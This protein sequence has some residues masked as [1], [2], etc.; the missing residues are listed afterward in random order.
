M[1]DARQIINR[2]ADLKSQRTVHEDAWRECFEYSWPSRADGFN[3]VRQD[4]QQILDKKAQNV[5]ST[6][7]DAGRLLA[8]AIQSGAT[9]AN[10]RWF[11]LD[12]NGADDQATR[13]LDDAAQTLFELIH[14]ANFDAA[15]FE[16]CIDIVGAG[17]FA[18]YVD[19]ESAGGGFNFEQ[20]PISQLYV[21]SSRPG[22]RIDI[23]YRC[24]ELTAQQCV[25]AFGRDAVSESTRKLLDKAPQQK[26]KLVRA[27]EP[28]AQYVPGSG[29]ARN[30][31]VQSCTIE[32]ESQ[33]IV[34]ESGYH[35]MPVIV[36]RWML[37][38]NSF[39]AI[40]P[41][42]DA[43][44]DVRMLNELKSMQLAAADISIAGMWIAADDGILNPRTLK[45]GPR[46]IIVAN[47]VDSMKSLSTGSDFQLGE[48]FVAN[49]QNQIRKTLMADQLEPQNGPTRTATEVNVRVSLLRQLL[50]PVYGRLQAEYLA[51]LVERCFG[52]AY[53]AGVLGQPPQSLQGR[54]FQV[55]YISPLA[56]AQKLEDVYAIERFNQNVALISQAK[57]GV[58]DL[59]DADQQARTLAE[60]L[61]VPLNTILDA[62]SVQKLRD[63][64]AQ[65]S[66]QQAQSAQQQQVQQALGQAALQKVAA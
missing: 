26:V 39:Y 57:P 51:P 27:I 20:W 43:L 13:W 50:A 34:R 32:I 9:P 49:L 41:M 6:A 22:G 30:L 58:L 35:E 24:F 38:P 54:D 66:A 7:T 55:K 42:F 29:M 16:C 47:S 31:P 37:I 25:T 19:D 17:W 14:G 61:G 1:A 46:K 4:A 36:P 18:L 53:R 59:I 28:R 23:V 11:Q 33:H 40:G 63:Q 21:A 8:S 64:R 10:S 62:E 48:V 65:Q 12:V 5:D 44:P 45:V 60:A 2:L 3:S 56:R 52:L 15:A